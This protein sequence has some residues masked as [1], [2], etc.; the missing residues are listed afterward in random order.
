ML[1][2]FLWFVSNDSRFFNGALNILE[3]QHNGVEV[4]NL[5]AVAPIQLT[6]DGKIVPF[7]PLDRLTGGGYEVLIV[8]GAKQIGMNKITKAARQLHLPEKKLLGDWIVI[9]PG[10][11]LE[12]KTSLIDM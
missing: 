3:R 9:I 11:T 1:K 12:K 10:F 7:V 2:V 6:K 4:V 8:V 5:T